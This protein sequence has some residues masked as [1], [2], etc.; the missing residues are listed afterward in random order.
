MFFNLSKIQTPNFPFHY[1]FDCGLVLSTDDGWTQTD[2]V[3]HKG[4]KLSAGNGNHVW[5]ECNGASVT[6]K[7]DKDRSFPMW[8]CNDCVTNIGECGKSIPAKWQ[9]TVNSDMTTSGCNLQPYTVRKDLTDEGVVDFIHETLLQTYD[10]FLTQNTRP[11]RLFLSGGIDTTTAWAYLDH[12]TKDYEI[13]DYEYI[14][15]TPFYKRNSKDIL[16]FWGYQQ[17]HLWDED[18][19]LVSGGNGDENLLRGPFTLAIALKQYGLTF[20]DILQPQDYHYKYLLKKEQNVDDVFATIRSVPHFILDTNVNDHQH[21]HIDRTLT[22][23]PFKDIRLLE[24]MLSGSKDLLI[25]QAR[26][27]WVNK[28]LVRR[29]D[30]SKLSVLSNQKN[31]FQLENT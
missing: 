3:V 13:C 23:T 1:H 27:A 6:I 15:H 21:W 16:K 17:I 19:V 25:N 11:L 24:A 10:E 7:H 31:H 2:N 9:L 12:F 30:A 20:E 5:F 29:L 4:Y 28:E 22:F 18:C 8:Q 26:D 14:K